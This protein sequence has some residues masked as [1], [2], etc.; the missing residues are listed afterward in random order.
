MPSFQ[1]F[2]IESKGKPIL[3]EDKIL[4]LGDFFPIND[5]DKLIIT[6]EKVN[7]E[8]EQGV[9]LSFKGTFEVEG[10]IFENKISFWKGDA[11][12]QIQIVV[13]PEKGSS[14]ILVKNLWQNTDHL[15][16]KF[17]NSGVNGAAMI[18]KEVPNGRR[19][20][21]NDGHPDDNFDDIVFSIQKVVCWYPSN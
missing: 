17:I 3:Y 8:W 9:G 10:Q 11:P 4:H 5:N 19:Y 2:F 6:L 12:D 21:C 7:S 18:I 15:G 14:S 1:S 20:Y 16:N 13:H